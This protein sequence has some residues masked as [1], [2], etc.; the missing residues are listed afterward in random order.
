ME[1]NTQ[2][3]YASSQLLKAVDKS[4]KTSYLSLIHDRIRRRV[5]KA[6]EY[7]ISSVANSNYISAGQINVPIVFRRP[8]GP[9]AG[10]GAQHS[11]YYIY[12][13]GVWIGSDGYLIN[14][15]KV[16]GFLLV[17][18]TRYKCSFRYL[19][20][21]LVCY[22]MGKMENEERVKNIC[23]RKLQGIPSLQ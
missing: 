19:L 16:D 17:K 21:N 4:S 20:K 12:G 11:Q 6:I 7:V 13:L 3:F 5:S 2:T 18:A 8:N 23:H 22:F 1:T 9:A 15:T 10:V 14:H